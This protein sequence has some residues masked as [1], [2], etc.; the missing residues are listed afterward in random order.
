MLKPSITTLSFVLILL[1]FGVSAQYNGIKF[2]K[3]SEKELKM[4]VYE[5]DPDAGAVILSK[6]GTFD[7]STLKFR[8]HLRVK[9]LKKSAVD[10]WSNWSFWTPSKA[11]FRIMVA[12]W[13]NNKIVRQKAGKENLKIEEDN[14]GNNEYNVLAPNVRAGSIIDIEYEHFLLPYEFYFQ[15]LIPVIYSELQIGNSKDVFYN[16]MFFGLEPVQYIE[17]KNLW[18]AKDIPA[19]K[20]EPYMSHYSNYLSKISFQIEASNLYHHYHHYFRSSWY[21]IK[22]DLRQ[23]R[24]FGRALN[25]SNFLNSFVKQMNALDLQLDRKVDT[26]F[27]YVRSQIHWNE[28]KRL[29]I[30]DP[31]YNNFVK[32]HS[33]NSA[34][35]NLTLVALLNKMN[36]KAYPV[37]LSTRNNGKL[38]RY[39]P[40]ISRLNYVVAYVQESGMLLDAANASTVPGMLP[41]YCLNGEGLVID[42]NSDELNWVSL[43]SNFKHLE[44]Q[45]WGFKYF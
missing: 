9:I 25:N 42:D 45:N 34:E 21:H 28:Q 23:N 33:G 43:T 41:D 38:L 31:D 4:T 5:N 2:G 39:R 30:S 36:I 29:Y 14:F 11:N 1:S 16:K 15:D 10:Q 32:D 17:K 3:F 18:I 35:I 7:A 40:N 44:T 6:I 19:F 13:E 37:V 24:W 20:E 8:H 27:A 22:A 12:N 26:A